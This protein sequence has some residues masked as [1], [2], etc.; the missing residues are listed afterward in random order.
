MANQSLLVKYKT[1]STLIKIIIINGLL[2][3]SIRLTAFFFE[4]RI[5]DITASFVLPDDFLSMFSQPW[6]LITYGF[7][8]HDFWHIFWNMLILYWFGSIFLNLFKGKRLLTIYLLGIICGGLLFMLAFNIFPVFSNSLNYLLGASAGVRAVMIFIAAYNPNAEM[9]IFIFNVKL[10]H[11]GVFVI[12]MDLLQMTSSGN[13]G[14]MLAHI[15]G[16]IFG[17]VYARQLVKGNDI[18]VWFENILNWFSNIFKT[19]K[20]KPFKK[21]HKTKQRTSRGT[22]TTRTSVN[23]DEHQQKIDAILDKISKSGYASLS[24]TEKD[25]LFNAGNKN[26]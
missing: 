26:D 17:Y 14:G 20:Q 7:I 25:F 2:F 13:A 22:K 12:L 9:R 3:L 10:W 1:A 21:V 18:G 16:A 23:K 24:K 6:S 15:G 11:I 4:I 8:H 5:E 19:R